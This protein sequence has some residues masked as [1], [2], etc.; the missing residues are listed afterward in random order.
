MELE[1]GTE[2]VAVSIHLADNSLMDA[3]D[4]MGT[5]FAPA[6]EPTLEEK[7]EALGLT[8]EEVEKIMWL[9]KDKTKRK[10]AAGYLSSGK[11]L[12]SHYLTVRLKCELCGTLKKVYYHM[13]QEKGETFLRGLRMSLTEMT[14]E[15]LER[16][17][18]DKFVHTCGSCETVLNQLSK[19]ELVA[20]LLDKSEE[21]HKIWEGRRKFHLTA[22]A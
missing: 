2:A 1:V 13:V 22:Q 21:V 11:K 4:R 19:E 14:D 12:P 5:T 8:A 9:A 18:T 17:T 16:K 3:V 20:K 15:S 7:A 10:E 6:K